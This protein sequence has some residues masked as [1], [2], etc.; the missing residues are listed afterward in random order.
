MGDD[1]NAVLPGIEIG[2]EHAVIV[3]ELELQASPLLDLESGP[4]EVS[5]E[6]LG[7]HPGEPSHLPM[8]RNDLD[9]LFGRG[10]R[11]RLGGAGRKEQG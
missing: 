10:W 1:E 8:G 7:R 6:V 11:R 3:A 9:W 4:S 5:G 2:V